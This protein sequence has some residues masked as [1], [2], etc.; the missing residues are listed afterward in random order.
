MKKSERKELLNKVIENINKELRKNY[1]GPLTERYT[2]IIL[3]T[4][5]STKT[6]Q[7][8]LKAT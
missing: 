5:L 4:K 3:N 6:N 7:N 2:N 8:S 1:A